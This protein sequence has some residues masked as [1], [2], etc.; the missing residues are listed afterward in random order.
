VDLSGRAYL[1]ESF[2]DI[3]EH[4]KLTEN[5]QKA[6]RAA[7][8]AN[9]V[10][11]QFLANMS[12][13]LRTPMNGVIG[14][15]ELL[16]GTDMTVEQ[17]E[18]AK[19]VQKSAN[20]L[21]AV[22]DQVLEFTHFETDQNLDM[23][24][25]DLHKLVDEVVDLLA[26]QAA[27]K[28]LGLSF[29]IRPDVPSQVR[30]DA[31]RLRRV[32]LNLGNNA[33]K[34]TEKG[35]ISIEVSL[36]EPQNGAEEKPGEW[37]ARFCIIDTGIGIPPHKKDEI[38]QSF[39]QADSSMSRKYGGTGLGLA[40]SK[41]QVEL[42]GGD[43]GFESVQG[44]GS[45]FWFAVPLKKQLQDRE[46]RPSPTSIMQTASGSSPVAADNG[47]ATS[48]SLQPVR[49]KETKAVRILLA[50]DNPINQKVAVLI[51]KKLGYEAHVVS[52][53]KEAIEAL[54]KSAY[55]LVL[56]DVQMPEMD[57]L[58]A[59]A[60]IR[61]SHS[62]VKN[63]QIPILAMTSHICKD[64]RQRCEEHGMNGFLSKPIQPEAL[65]RVI[66]EVLG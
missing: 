14:M 13:E 60:M 66:E 3:S 61:N 44:G 32:L 63:H 49:E 45:A 23:H 8:A 16:L 39:S 38:F 48:K 43:I 26:G 22:I 54:E 51:L 46:K 17:R 58:T 1:V 57:G 41:R 33:V 64:D 53:G 18:F 7:E 5:L 59:A 12:H 47:E 55:D 40:M 27:Q 11:T 52:N 15:T 35:R 31:D 29:S 34:F 6:K 42:L 24:D 25:F 21:L 50:E 19:V 2:V 4:K 62:H 37:M 20:A 36:D 65:A 10:K 9:T 28:A 56:M 30:G